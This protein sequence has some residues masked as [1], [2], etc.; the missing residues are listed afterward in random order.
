MCRPSGAHRIQL[1]T[2]TFRSGLTHSA[3]PA[4]DRGRTSQLIWNGTRLTHSRQNGCEWNRRNVG[5]N[6]DAPSLSYHSPTPEGWHELAQV[7]KP[8]ESFA[9]KEVEPR[10]GRYRRSHTSRPTAGRPGSRIS[11]S[12]CADSRLVVSIPATCCACPGVTVGSRRGFWR[13]DSDA[14][15]NSRCGSDKTLQRAW[16]QSPDT[17][18]RGVR[19]FYGKSPV[20]LDF[21]QR[22]FN[23][24]RIMLEA[25]SVPQ[26]AR[27]SHECRAL[28]F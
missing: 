1:S 15:G 23:V 24:S 17:S 14:L 11:R 25:R 20:P 7:R 27:H 12:S 6:Q 5:R 21:V 16:R 8:W 19:A 26:C 13:C 2:Q 9:Q 18:N 3:P 4:L 22:H 10:R 28:L